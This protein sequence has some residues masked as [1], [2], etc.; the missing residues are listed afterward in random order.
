MVLFAEHVGGEGTDEPG[1]HRAVPAG[2]LPPRAGPGSEHTQPAVEVPQQVGGEDVPE[3]G[4]DLVQVDGEDV[5]LAGHRARVVVV[6]GEE[7]RV[8]TD[9]GLV[10]RIEQP[11]V[12]LGAVAV[13]PQGVAASRV[14]SGAGFGQKDVQLGGAGPPRSA[15]AVAEQVERGVLVGGFLLG[16]A[17]DE[18][19]GAGDAEAF[20]VVE[21][22]VEEP[23]VEPL[24]DDALQARRSGL[25]AEIEGDAPGFGHPLQ[26]FGVHA[27]HSGGDPP[28][29]AAV[30]DGVAEVQHLAAVDGEEVVLQ[31]ESQCSITVVE[32][33]EVGNQP[34]RRLRR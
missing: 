21:G 8:L 28:G 4:E 14:L 9:A 10:V 12:E 11:A 19:Y 26:Q 20:G 34:G 23:E 24:L 18:G 30:A 31:L 29:V 5:V 3:F 17:G 7:V 16:V 1:V 22:R 25:D 32:P 15:E 6:G 33:V 2:V 13:V 27:V